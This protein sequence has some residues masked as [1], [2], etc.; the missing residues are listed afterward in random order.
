MTHGRGQS[1]ESRPDRVERSTRAGLPP[2]EVMVESD[3][4]LAELARLLGD[5]EESLIPGRSRA[6]PRPPAMGEDER[7]LREAEWWLSEYFEHR[8]E[9]EG[10]LKVLG[11]TR[12]PMNVAAAD[13]R[14][15]VLLGLIDLERAVCTALGGGISPTDLTRPGVTPWAGPTCRDRDCMHDSCV[16]IRVSRQPMSIEERLIRRLR[17]LLDRVPDVPELL[18]RVHRDTRR[19]LLAASAGVEPEPVS[20][21]GSCPICGERSLF[22]YH[23]RDY[24][25]CDN[26]ECRCSS[27]DCWCRNEE[28]PRLHMWPRSQWGRLAEWLAASAR[29]EQEAAAIAAADAAAAAE[30]SEA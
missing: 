29:V 24:A 5:L 21:L 16:R 20:L 26:A 14:R 17:G 9:Q 4:N 27:V 12:V 18:D 30:R 13:A 7:Q 2:A 25:Q 1:G 8:L 23:D 15:M 3:I 19:L 11:R 6:W 28:R 10:L 22:V